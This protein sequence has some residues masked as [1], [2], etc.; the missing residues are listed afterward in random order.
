MRGALVIWAILLLGA[1]GAFVAIE[2]R[3]SEDAFKSLQSSSL[4]LVP[5]GLLSGASVAVEVARAPEPVAAGHRTPAERADCEPKG[6]GTLRNPW[7]CTVRY[8]SGREAHYLVEVQ[9]DGSYSGVGSGF[10]NG[11]CIKVPTLE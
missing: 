2:G 7:V 10:I 11:C 1:A 3:G 4:T 8:R 9:P 6:S 5:S